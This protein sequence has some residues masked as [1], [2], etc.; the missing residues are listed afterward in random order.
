MRTSMRTKDPPKTG[1]GSALPAEQG[2]YDDLQCY[3]LAH[4]DAAFV[5]QH[6]VDAWT[7]QQADVHTKPIA[8]TFALA[9][10]S[11]HVVK[12]LSGRQVQLAHM[13]LARNK[14]AWPSFT[15]PRER[16]LVRAHQVPAGSAG[17][18]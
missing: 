9:G 13:A 7:A 16:G 10:L 5:H 17:P 4:G 3:T 12:G 1:P 8:L 15:L 2:A 14:R 18:S 11:L 6:V